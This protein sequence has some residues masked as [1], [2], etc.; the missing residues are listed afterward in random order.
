MEQP[1]A[2]ITFWR[3]DVHKIRER[4]KYLLNYIQRSKCN[5][6]IK[7]D[8]VTTASSVYKLLDKGKVK[9][10]DKRRQADHAKMGN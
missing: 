10:A 5:E 3:S 7:K 9:D 6:L 4:V 2:I 8:A 1:N